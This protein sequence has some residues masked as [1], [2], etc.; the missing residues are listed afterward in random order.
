V[1]DTPATFGE[2]LRMRRESLGLAR[3]QLAGLV[4]CTTAAL[5]QWEI[6]RNHPKEVMLLR[7]AA[8]LQITV[9]DLAGE[10]MGFDRTTVQRRAR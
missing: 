3:K 2:R 1:S 5:G 4:N 6:G 10:R 9:E 8:A 7:L